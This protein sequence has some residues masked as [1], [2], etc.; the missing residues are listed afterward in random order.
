MLLQFKRETRTVMQSH[1]DPGNILL[2]A[3]LPDAIRIKRTKALLVSDLCEGFRLTY[4]YIH[5]LVEYAQVERKI[6][7]AKVSVTF[8]ADDTHP[9]FKHGKAP[10]GKL[11]TAAGL[12]PSERTG[13]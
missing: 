1:A 13:S 5:Y 3:E 6:Q 2:D 7:K 10:L 9:G 11:N 8:L 12:N 4:S